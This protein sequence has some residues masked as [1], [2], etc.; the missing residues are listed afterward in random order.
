VT[1]RLRLDFATRS[2]AQETTNM[3]LLNERFQEVVTAAQ[4]IGFKK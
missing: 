4:G 3:L 2:P 1:E